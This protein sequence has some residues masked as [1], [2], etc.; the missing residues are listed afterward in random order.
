MVDGTLEPLHQPSPISEPAKCYNFVY[1]P[2][3]FQRKAGLGYAFVNMVTTADGQRIRDKLNKFQSWTI[4]T[5]KVLEVVWSEQSQGLEA[6]VDRYRN[7]PVMHPDVADRC[8][9]VL[10]EDGI[11]VA[12]PEPSKVLRP[13]RFK[14][15]TKQT[16]R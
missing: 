2:M 10:L 4:A 7:S 5:Q 9:P 14:L 11:P 16:R 13:P 15:L 12:F 1:M 6:H 8:K 3:D